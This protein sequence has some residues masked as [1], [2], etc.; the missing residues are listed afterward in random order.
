LETICPRWNATTLLRPRSSGVTSIG[1]R[2][3]NRRFRGALNGA[4]FDPASPGL[5]VARASG[6]RGFAVASR[7]GAMLMISAVSAIIWPCGVTALIG[8]QE[9]LTAARGMCETGAPADVTTR[10]RRILFGK[11]LSSFG[12]G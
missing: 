2:A 10:S 4:V 12:D 6:K 9:E 1:R 8:L 7:H 5:G 11:R 3:M